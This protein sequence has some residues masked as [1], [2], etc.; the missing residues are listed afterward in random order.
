MPTTTNALWTIKADGAHGSNP[1]GNQTALVG[2]HLAI[3]TDSNGTHYQFQGP[4]GGNAAQVTSPGASLPSL[5]YDFPVF[6]S[7]LG[8]PLAQNWYI[9]IKSSTH[10]QDEKDAHGDWSNLPF[11]PEFAEVDPDTWTAQAG[12]GAGGHPEDAAAAKA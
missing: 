6:N 3:I 5:P 9:R 12:S 1:Q 10:G 2:C 11:T 7:Q 4:G 8:G